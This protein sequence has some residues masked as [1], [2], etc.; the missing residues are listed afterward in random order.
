MPLRWCTLLN[1]LL[2][3]VGFCFRGTS[4]LYHSLVISTILLICFNAEP[5]ICREKEPQ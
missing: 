1:Q 2:A 3:V 5:D 4:Q